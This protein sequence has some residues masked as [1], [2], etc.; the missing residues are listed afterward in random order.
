MV[1]II[2]QIIYL[3]LYVFIITLLTR[4]VFSA[5]LSYGRRWRPGRGAA[6]ALEVVWSVTDPPI[7]VFRRVIPPLRIGTVSLDL[8]SILLLVILFLLLAFVVQPLI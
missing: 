6:A 7:R 3:V 1:S 5:V 8:A 2:F 4:F